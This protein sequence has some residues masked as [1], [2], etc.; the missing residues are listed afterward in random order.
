MDLGMIPG[1]YPKYIQ[2]YKHLEADFYAQSVWQ[3]LTQILVI[4][5]EFYTTTPKS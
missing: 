2:F 1:S 3:H 4:S 5:S